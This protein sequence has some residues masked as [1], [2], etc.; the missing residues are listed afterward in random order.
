MLIAPAPLAIPISTANPPTEAVASEAAQKTPITRPPATSDNPN[1]RSSTDSNEQPK[2]LQDSNKENAQVETRQEGSAQDNE[3]QKQQNRQ[4]Q[5]EQAIERQ[6]IESLKK[7]DRE[8]RAHEL[9]HAAVG[10]QFAGSPQ[11]TFKTGPDGKRYA[12][13]G[14]VAIDISRAASPEATLS[15]MNQ[16]KRA[17]L[18]P[19]N[20]SSQDRS[21]AAAANQIANQARVEI[22]QQAVQEN[23]SPETS[24]KPELTIGSNKS[25]SSD[26]TNSTQRESRSQNR[27][28]FNPV[29]A[30]IASSRL[31]QRIIASGALDD[32]SQQSIVSRSA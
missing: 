9:A 5:R 3:E 4:E 31:N 27:Q 2:G 7:R 18:A 20:P 11:L 8:V 29:A 19:A 23:Q 28:I 12:V 1:T 21:V 25:E 30:R 13:A 10:G 14:E 16:I 17:A 24:E 32:P 22:R 26:E 6:E 15:K